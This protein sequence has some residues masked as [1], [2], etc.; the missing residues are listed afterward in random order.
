MSALPV[1]FN[2]SLISE[3]TGDNQFNQEIWLLHGY[4]SNEGDLSALSPYFSRHYT[5]RSLRATFPL[6][7]GGFAWYG[8]DFDFNGLKET[9]L[10]QAQESLLLISDALDWHKS[11]YPNSP[12]PVLM[13]FSQGG[14]LCNAISFSFPEKVNSIVSIASYYPLE[15]PFLKHIKGKVPHFVALGTEDAVVPISMSIPTFEKAQTDFNIVLEI[16]TYKMPHSISQECFS[17]IIKFIDKSLKR[18]S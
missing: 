11:I 7:T 6:P 5:I 2:D 9:N 4:A 14:I 8:I 17:D 16:G 18:N 10:P 15:W 13:G 1:A 12:R 3:G